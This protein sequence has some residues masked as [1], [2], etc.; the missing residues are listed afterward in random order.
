[1]TGSIHNLV[2]CSAPPHLVLHV[3]P[4]AQQNVASLSLSLSLALSRS[5]SFPLSLSLL[6]LSLSGARQL[7]APRHP[8]GPP[9]PPPGPRPPARHHRPPGAPARLGR[10]SPARLCA[11]ARCAPTH[12][13]RRRRRRIPV[14]PARPGRPLRLPPAARRRRCAPPPPPRARLRGPHDSAWRPVGRLCAA[15]ARAAAAP[16]GWTRLGLPAQVR[17]RGRCPLPLP[18]LPIL[19][20]PMYKNMNYNNSRRSGGS[21]GTARPP[22]SPPPSQR[23]P[24]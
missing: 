17:A 10:L 22:P 6:S 2:R 3:Y 16:T 7:A 20:D 19:A 15:C 14:G 4:E 13:R 8:R 18:H 9:R 23:W 24:S 5:P 11:G 12:R 1:M 21:L